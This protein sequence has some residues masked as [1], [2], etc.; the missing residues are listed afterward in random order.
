MDNKY[1]IE[2]YVRMSK[3]VVLEKD[4]ENKLNTERRSN[5]DVLKTVE[6]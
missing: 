4:V 1:K 3:N 6:E 2:G 5:G